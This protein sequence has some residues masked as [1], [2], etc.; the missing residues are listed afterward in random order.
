MRARSVC[1]ADECGEAAT[2]R[3]RCE[4][5]RRRINASAWRR[6]VRAVVV[7]DAG[8]CWLC[9]K[10]GATSADHVRRWADG[11]TDEMSNLRAVH[12]TCNK[13]RG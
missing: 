9:G 11:G 6:I 3:G 12:V 5:H 2:Y 10:Q 13:Q 4:R 7:R 1:A 8:I